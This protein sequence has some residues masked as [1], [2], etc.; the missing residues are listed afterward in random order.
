MG[1]AVNKHS[2]AVAS[3]LA[4]VYMHIG[5]LLHDLFPLALPQECPERELASVSHGSTVCLC[6][7]AIRTILPPFGYR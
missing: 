1:V 4:V 3:I 7:A 5:P 2:V 6:M